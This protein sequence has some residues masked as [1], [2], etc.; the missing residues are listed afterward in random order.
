VSGL[1]VL[2]VIAL[3][4]AVA[5]IVW[6]IVALVRRQRYIGSIRQRGWSFVNSPTFDAV[7][8]LSNPP[9]GLGFVRKPDDQI[10]GL[11]AAGRPF[12]VI[13]YKSTYWSGWVGMVTLSRRLPE[14]WIT[15][16]ETAP[17]YG[18]LAHGV[19]APPQLGPGWQIGAMDPA[20]AQEVLTSQLCVQLGAMA[21]GQPGVNLGID[22]DQVVVLNP[23]R[24]E[25]DQLGQWLEQLGAIAA[26]IDATPLDHWIQPEPEP[27][28]RF[29]HHPDWYWI[30]VDDSL[31]QY[32]PINR[33][34]YGHRTEDVIRG[35]DGDG[36]PFVAFQHHWKTSHTESYT[37][38]N[39]NSQTRTVVDHHSEPILGFQLPARMPQ[40][41]VGQR[42]LRKGIGFE[43]NA[44]NERFAVFSAD[45]KF[46]YD[47]VHPRQ[48]EY[49]MATPGA[50]FRIV[51][52][53]VWFTPGEHSQPAIAFCSAYLRGFLGWVPRFV[54][55][56]LGLPD[57][58]YPNR[59]TTAG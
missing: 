57:T 39:G 27:R 35:R 3:L 42:G 46:A 37:D 6:G 50:P 36:P 1:V 52:D 53:W 21:A 14:L 33:G 38:S 23:P 5:A 49:L 19:V 8:R 11:T 31:L 55:R 15:G 17:R 32:T 34:G 40:L 44:L 25:I 51:E 22:G 30:G 16:G 28:L 20:F 12:Q 2:M 45:T 58:P 18:V 29:Y 47:V 48:M 24:K 56:N 9:F 13:E 59:E 26:A 4:L 41:S 43:S 10:T 54:W 7:A